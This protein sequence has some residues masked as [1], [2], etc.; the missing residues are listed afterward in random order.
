MKGYG[1]TKSRLRIFFH[2]PVAPTRPICPGGPCVP[3]DPV[4]PGCPVDPVGPG[5][6][7]SPVG[8]K[9]PVG[10]MGPTGPVE[11]KTKRGSPYVKLRMCVPNETKQ[12]AAGKRKG[13]YTFY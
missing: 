10:P 2:L 12:N 11:F 1:D 4:R 6:P 8:P 5:R 13:T 9:G 3:E 7:T